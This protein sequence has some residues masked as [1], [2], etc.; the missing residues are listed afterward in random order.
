MLLLPV[1]LLLPPPSQRTCMFREPIRFANSS[2]YDTI[3]ASCITNICMSDPLRFSGATAASA[4]KAPR[5]HISVSLGRRLLQ[6]QLDRW[7]PTE[8]DKRETI[9]SAYS[10]LR[11]GSTDPMGPGDAFTYDSAEASATSNY[12]GVYYSDGRCSQQQN[13]PTT[14]AA[15]LLLMDCWVLSKSSTHSVLQH[16]QQQ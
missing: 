3:P 9:A 12:S 4:P 1:V 11:N 6:L 8:Q 7:H 2:L 10:S 13:S 15:A 14:A 5:P 16:R